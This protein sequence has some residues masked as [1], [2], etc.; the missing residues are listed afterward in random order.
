M[1]E[2]RFSACPECGATAEVV[3][4]GCADS[5]DGPVEMVR[6]RCV[7]RHWFLM[8]ADSLPAPVEAPRPAR[9]RRT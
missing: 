8:A 1:D 9:T 2:T 3:P 5:T 6:V 7:E 4:E